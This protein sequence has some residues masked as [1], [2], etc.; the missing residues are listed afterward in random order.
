MTK[1]YKV[2]NP[3]FTCK[4]FQYE[5]GKRYKH[6]GEIEICGSGFHFCEKLID[7]YAY[8][9]FDQNNK[10][11]EIVAHGTVLADGNKS[12]TNE[13]EIVKEISWNDC[14]NIVNTGKGNTGRGNTGDLNTGDRNTGDRNT[15]DL[16]TGDRNTGDLNTGDLNTGDRNTG[17][18]N[19]GHRNTGHWNTGDL[20][21]G[22]RN[23]GHW[24]AGDRN[25]GDLN[26]GDLNKTSCSSGVLCTKEQKILIFD[27]KSNM[28]ISDWR[29]SDFA[30]LFFDYNI[31]VWVDESAMTDQ[32]KIDHPK[33]Y[34]QEGYLKS[35][36]PEEAWQRWYKEKTP[37]E[38][39]LL[40]QIP[41]FDSAKFEYITGLKI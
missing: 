20:N 2:F 4:G 21:T 33:F 28:T 13:I 7:C 23:T 26:T 32:E 27:K 38:I 39:E 3:D 37:E 10:I 11:A 24:N 22:D 25:T 1:G 6:E 5:V 34:V 18:W 16:N 12:C 8:Y 9:T 31:N 30:K 17:H 15:G 14:L 41:N 40:K 19:T 35:I 36:T 29:N